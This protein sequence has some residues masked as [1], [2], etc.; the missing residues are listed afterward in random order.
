MVLM[1]PVWTP[2]SDRTFVTTLEP[3]RVNVGLVV[4]DDAAILIDSGNTAEQGA[5]LLASAREQD[6]KSVV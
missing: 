3:D 6:R 4:G 5:A 1:T 2:V